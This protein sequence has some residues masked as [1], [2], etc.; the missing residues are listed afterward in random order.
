MYLGNGEAEVVA[1][2]STYTIVL[3]FSLGTAARF[4]PNLTYISGELCCKDDLSLLLAA[5]SDVTQPSQGANAPLGSL[6]LGDM[7]EAAVRYL[8]LVNG[9]NFLAVISL[10]LC[11][12]RSLTGKPLRYHF[13]AAYHAANSMVDPWQRTFLTDALVRGK[14][15]Y[16]TL[17]TA[18][19]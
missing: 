4:I 7:F 11:R 19:Q 15:R 2:W 1:R 16:I 9:F 14:T 18:G 13:S 10:I 12:R 8:L 6:S 3:L 17:V 5:G